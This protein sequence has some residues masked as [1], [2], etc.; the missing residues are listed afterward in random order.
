[1]P[2]RSTGGARKHALRRLARA[3]VRGAFVLALAGCSGPPVL[4]VG[5]VGYSED[6]VDLLDA[7]QRALLA[8]LTALGLVMADGR[9]EALA[10]PFVEREMR[11]LMLQR[12]AMEEAVE[13]AG[14]DEAELR[15]AYSR[16]PFPELVVRHLVVVSERWRPEAHR[17][18]ARALAEE[19][20]ARA[21]AGEPFE[22]LAGEYS[23]EPGAAERG[24]LLTPGREETWVP[25]FWTAA[26]ALEEGEVSGV[27]ESEFGFHV[28]RLEER[29][30]VPFE[31]VRGEVLERFVNLPAALTRARGWA[32]SQTS[33][34]R[35]DT[36]AV[37]AWREAAILSRDTVLVTWA[38]EAGSGA[39][40][41]ES[42]ERY[43]MTLGTDI[44]G[45]VLESDLAA[46][47][48]LAEA[49][50]Q[51]SMLAERARRRG[52]EPSIA[53][54]AALESRWSARIAGWAGAFGFRE[55]M[56]NR[57]VKQASLEAL[58]S[59]GQTAAIA[60]RELSS[61]SGVLRSLVPVSEPAQSARSADTVNSD[62]SA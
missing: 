16:A 39:L 28:I 18:S 38:G 57:A 53:Q 59:R 5:P 33:S 27:V 2:A 29:R 20:Y 6:E 37:V 49:A 11:S 50:A 26:N 19:A 31:E 45:H 47:I 10:T 24:G 23:D 1:M 15:E 40:S 46:T 32:E 30:A 13:D 9:T 4:E 55:G 42:F 56:S 21:V 54:R 25:E 17:D 60:R 58:G 8:D 61:L 35:V 3:T 7:E 43:L 12:L 51:A 22:A 48:A 44:R 52:L 36:G 14:M 41:A 34:L 62:T